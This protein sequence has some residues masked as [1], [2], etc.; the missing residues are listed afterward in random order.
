M[1]D[2]EL[3]QAPAN[4]AEL[5]EKRFEIELEFLQ[6]LS[7]PMYLQCG[8]SFLRFQPSLILTVLLISDLAQRGFMRDPAF[9]NYLD[10]LQY[11]KRP[12]YAKFVVYPDS[13]AILD[14]L[15]HAVFREEIAKSEV[16]SFV[17]DKEYRTWANARNNRSKG[18]EP[19]K[20]EAVEAIKME[21]ET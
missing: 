10:Y 11:W 5:E 12:E 14:L 1:D 13:L 15:Q 19:A 20:D 21:A 17:H 4:A 2:A 6:M 9:V 3:N 16:A 18:V 8:P 7:H